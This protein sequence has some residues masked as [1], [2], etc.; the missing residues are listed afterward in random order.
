MGEEDHGRGER[1]RAVDSRPRIRKQCAAESKH[2]KRIQ[3]VENDVRQ[4]IAKRIRAPQAAIDNLAEDEKRAKE[5]SV[6]LVPGTEK[7]Q[8][9][10][11]P[12]CAKSFDKK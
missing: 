2:K 4:V 6:F 5:P 11:L 9:R 10:T 1:D 3:S 12:T 8:P 7:S